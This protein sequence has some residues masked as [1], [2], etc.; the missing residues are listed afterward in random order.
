MIFVDTSA[1]LSILLPDDLNH[2]RAVQTWRDLLEKDKALLTNNYVLVESIVIIQKRLGISKVR[3]FQEKILPLL[4]IEW[5]DEKEHAATLQRM[6]AANRRQLSL[7]DCSS[8]E[9]MQRLD[10]QKAFTF[11][12]HF[13]EQGFEIIP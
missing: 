10:V 5:V 9:T 7:V 1:I 11:D 6:L 13:A 8:F 2:A 4:Q 3:D 12:S